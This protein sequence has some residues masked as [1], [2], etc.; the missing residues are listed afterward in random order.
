MLPDA[1]GVSLRDDAQR[2]KSFGDVG[3]SVGKYHQKIIRTQDRFPK[4]LF[5]FGGP[6]GTRT[7]VP[8]VRG[9]YPRPLDDGTSEPVSRAQET[10][11]R[12]G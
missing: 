2:L 1:G 6:N 9:R 10:A 11:Y 7:R 3:N 12:N 8:G 4:P 5:P